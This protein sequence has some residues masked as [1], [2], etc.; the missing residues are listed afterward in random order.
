MKNIITK[1]QLI[2]DYQRFFIVTD[3]KIHFIT[4][5]RLLPVIDEGIFE[6][7]DYIDDSDKKPYTKAQMVLV[8]QSAG[9]F[10]EGTFQYIENPTEKMCLKAI[11]MNA[12]VI[13]S[14]RNPAK[15]LCLAALD[16]DPY[17]LEYIEY[18]TEELCLYAINKDPSTLKFVKKQTKKI[19]DAA[20]KISP[21]CPLCLKYISSQCE[22]LNQ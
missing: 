9:T 13:K 15:S 16:A 1:K 12:E 3:G 4:P 11:K 20:H 10:L 22:N 6:A 2:K 5:N 7:A 14:I 17:S 21:L 8:D 19:C 18:Q